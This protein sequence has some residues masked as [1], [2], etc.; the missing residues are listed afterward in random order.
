MG[1]ANGRG[2]GSWQREGVGGM[3]AANG[4]RYGSWQ[5]LCF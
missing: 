4:R 3:G 1:T 5:W 2:Y